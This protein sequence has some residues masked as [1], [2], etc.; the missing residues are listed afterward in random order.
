MRNSPCDTNARR[1]GRPAGTFPIRLLAAA[2]LSMVWPGFAHSAAMTVKDALGRSVQVALPVKRVVV[3]NSDTLEILRALRA[4]D[5]VAGVFSEIIHERQFWGELAARPKVG[6][7]RNPDMEAIA[8]L[9][10]GLVIAYGRNP[11]P[12]LER[13][14]ALFGIQVLRLDLYKVNTLEREVQVLGRMLERQKEAARFCEWYRRH[15]EPIREKT[16]RTRRHTS[17]YI[18]SYTDY[19]AAGPGSGGHEMCVLAG[20]SNIAG[21]LAIPYPRVTPEWVVSRN[22]EAIVKAASYGNGY[23]SVSTEQFNKRRDAIV[24]RPA[25]DHISAV[26]SGNVH[27]VDSAIWTGP[28]APHRHR[29]HGTLVSSRPL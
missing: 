12:L 3:L 18:E 13:K 1:P 20:G 4:T 24:K 28:R 16:A 27:V 10:P 22:P 6:S 15:L 14:M 2:L 25:W 8:G 29:V 19:H 21:E 5:I 11:G 23:M 26:A 17:V 9:Q 7:W